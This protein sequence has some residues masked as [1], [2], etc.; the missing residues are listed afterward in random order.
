MKKQF[1]RTSNIFSLLGI[2]LSTLNLW[3][4]EG[5][6]QKS[7]KLGKRLN[8]WNAADIDAWISRSALAEQSGGK[9]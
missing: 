5:K 8:I 1:Y 3:T 4:S 7:Q 6:F 2:P 9:A